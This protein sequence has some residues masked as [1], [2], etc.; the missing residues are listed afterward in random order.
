[1]SLRPAFLC[2]PTFLPSLAPPRL[3]D[4]D[5]GILLNSPDFWGPCCTV[6]GYA[7]LLLWGKFRVVPWV[8]LIWVIGSS[9]L[10]FLVRSVGTPVTLSQCLAVS[11]YSVLP[12]ILVVFTLIVLPPIPKVRTSPCLPLITMSLLLAGELRVVL[13]VPVTN[14]HSSLLPRTSPLPFLVTADRGPFDPVSGSGLGVT[15][16]LSGALPAFGH[17]YK[18]RPTHHAHHAHAALHISNPTRLG[19]TQR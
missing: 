3:R 19:Y 1:M 6:I 7:A 10:W 16:L 2:P 14:N 9:M 13:D 12:L 11:G 15:I 4:I 18:Q 8:I 5:H 17:H